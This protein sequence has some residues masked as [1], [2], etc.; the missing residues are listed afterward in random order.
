MFDWGAWR[1]LLSQCDSRGAR[2]SSLAR[3]PFRGRPLGFQP[4]E[5]RLLLAWQ[6]VFS[7]G[8][9]GAFPGT[10]WVASGSPSWGKTSF[11]AHTGSASIYS[12]GSSV[13]PPGPY[14]NN[15]NAWVEYGPFILTGATAA[16]LGFWYRN[17][18]NAVG[19]EFMWGASTDHVNYYGGQVSGDESTWRSE[20]LDLTS[21]PTLGNLAGAGQV[22]IAFA[23]QSDASGG[24]VG[25][26]VDDVVL[27]TL[28]AADAQGG[29]AAS[30]TSVAMN[31]TAVGAI[32]TAHDG[33]WFRFAAV[34]G[35]EYVFTT[36]D[37]GLGD[38]FLRLIDTNGTTQLRDDD[39]NGPGNMSQIVWTAPASDTY[40]LEVSG[41]GGAVGG[42]SL[43]IAEKA[44]VPD[45]HGNSAASAT[46][47]SVNVSTAGVIETVGDRDWFRFDAAGGGQYVIETSNNGL[48]DSLLRLLDTNGTSQLAFN[49]D[50]GVG[51]MSKITWTAPAS[52]SYFVEVSGYGQAI[53]GYHVQISGPPA[54][55]PPSLP[56]DYNRDHVVNAADYTVWRN[57]SGQ[58]GL[59]FY[60]GADGNG[61]GQITAADYELWKNH[62]GQAEP[63]AGA[64]ALEP[65]GGASNSADGPG[66]V[67]RAKSADAPVLN[68]LGQSSQRA[69]AFARES[70]SA[71]AAAWR[72]L[73]ASAPG[74]VKE[75]KKLAVATQ[76]ESR[77]EEAA[78]DAALLLWLNGQP[79]AEGVRNDQG[80]ALL[81]VRRA[82]DEAA[83]FRPDYLDAAIGTLAAPGKRL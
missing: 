77:D 36:L 75:V 57:S 45:D 23:F 34:A 52:G 64:A 73:F 29:N 44:P 69:A 28:A 17:A 61:D 39:D 31:S 16:T 76:A 24:D 83:M 8:F 12:V 32:E 10:A 47:V 27:T 11:D 53:G 40:Y 60:S 15:V 63:G 54:T 5:E 20:S 2:R 80:A 35:K 19:D 49:D 25:A 46:Q 62:F 9:E 79:L 7:D 50:G 51:N 71:A 48:G 13:A 82:S 72:E 14:P 30:A 26:F 33:D 65:P 41:Y 4:L 66:W 78:R 81:P 3:D 56:G 22:W 67:P 1:A 74:Y 21:V 43:E 58:T 42:Y 68:P 55:G 59:L 6:T 70:T 37:G 18:S 38:S